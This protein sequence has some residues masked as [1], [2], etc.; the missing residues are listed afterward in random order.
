MKPFQTLFNVCM[1]QLWKLLEKDMGVVSLMSIRHIAVPKDSDAQDALDAWEEEARKRGVMFIDD[2]PENLKGPS[3]FN[4]FTK[5]DLSRHNEIQARYNLAAQIKIAAW[6]LVG[7]SPQRTGDVAAT[8]TATGTNTAMAQSYAQT[9]PYFVQHGYLMN[10]VFQ[11]ML[12]AAQYI[13]SSKPV[14]TIK[15]LTNEGE[16]AF[17]QV[18]GSD[19]KSKDLWCFVTDRAEDVQSLR[20]FRQLAQAMLQNGATAYEIAEMYSTNSMRKIKS[21]MKK[22]KEQQM[23]YQQQAQQ[24]EQQKLEQEGQAEMMK[25]KFE[26][27]ENEKDRIHETYENALDRI[28]KKEAALIQALGRNENATADN[29]NSGIADALEVT[30]MS[31]DQQEANRK[32]ELELSK[33]QNEKSD[34]QEKMKL[35]KEKLQ[36]AREN[37][38][39]DKEIAQIN[40]KNRAAKAKT[41]PAKKKK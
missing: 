12:D 9:E 22:I 23:E 18:N 25:L 7:I 19:L 17:L 13:E 27:E 15:Y 34:I 31:F 38:Q 26:A 5:L 10:D 39:N 8:E 40:A 29:D 4:Q 6:E 14:S 16:Q 24:M 32:F 33:L 30:R 37:M 35:E 20:E 21:V 41:T 28:N 3:S 36:V 2:S 1:N 11:A